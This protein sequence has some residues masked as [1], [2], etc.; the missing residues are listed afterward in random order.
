ME[1]LDEFYYSEEFYEHLNETFIVLIPKYSDAKD[2]KD[3]RPIS[4]LSNVYKIIPK[5]LSTRLKL[6]MKAIIA[7]PLSAFV[8]GRQ[9]LDN[10]LIAIECIEDRRMPGRYGLLCKL[11]MEN[12]YDHVN[13]DF[14]DYILSIMRFGVKWRSWMFY[15]I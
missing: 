7:Q 1:V 14:L 11:D 10:V 4:L 5:V 3:Y 15:C 13:R 9:I 2:I 8:E 6:V 12:A